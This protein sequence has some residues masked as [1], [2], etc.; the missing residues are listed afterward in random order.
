MG[1]FIHLVCFYQVFCFSWFQVFSSGQQYLVKAFTTQAVLNYC[2][3]QQLCIMIDKLSLI[4]S[5]K[6]LFDSSP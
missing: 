4:L 2:I 1:S 5:S 6:S 3:K